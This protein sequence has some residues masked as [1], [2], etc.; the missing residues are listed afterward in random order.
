MV[1]ATGSQPSI[2][3]IDGL[4]RDRV[5]T[6]EDL[7]TASE[8][9]A[10]CVIIGGGAIGCES[11][12][13]LAGFGRAVTLVEVA[14]E[15]LDGVVEPRV[16]ACLRNR[17]DAIGVDVRVGAEV[18]AVQHGPDHHSV[19]FDGAPTARGE[20][21]LVAAGT[22]PVWDDL[23]LDTLGIDEPDVDADFVVS[24]RDWLRAIGDVNARSPWTHGAN[25]EAA[26]LAELLT[27]G[28]ARPEVSGMASCV[29][30]DP[31]A[32]SVGLTVADA[33]SAGHD[34][35]TGSAR[36]S[37][38]ARSSTDPGFDGVVVVVADRRTGALLGCSGVGPRFDDTVSIV[39]ALLGAGSTL[40]DA[41]R[42]V[43]PFPTMSQVL[44]PAFEDAI[45]SR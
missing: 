14:D 3:P 13:I 44:T 25:H 38:I 41:S 9:P 8:L 43:I 16:G 37:D 28:D 27:D 36:Y 35:I 26:R 15:L 21:L 1:V 11:A 7:M 33:T 45:A 5:W 10:S 23:G 4:A 6:S 34:V 40:D 42:L 31:P 17:L 18:Q 29:F 12:A 32:A 2:P 19:S 39:S 22:A 30:T 24:G 20:Q